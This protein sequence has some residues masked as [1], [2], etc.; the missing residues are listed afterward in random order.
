MSTKIMALCWPIVIPPTAKS[1]LISLADNANDDG[2][3]YPSIATI[4][5]RTCFKKDAVIDAIAWLERASLLTANRGN[6]R[7]TTYTLTP[8]NF[9][10]IEKASRRETS[11]AKPPVKQG[12]TTGR[13]KPPVGQTES[14]QSGKTTDQSGKTT[15]PV[16]QTDTNRQEPSIEPSLNHLVVSQ[17]DPDETSLQLACK[18]TWA[19]YSAAY[20]ARY[21]IQPVRNAKVSS[22][23]K[24]FVQRVG[25]ADAPAIAEFF[26]RLNDQFVVKRSHD[27]GTLL[28]NAE[29]YRTQCLTGTVMTTT[30]ANQLDR[31]ASNYDAVQEAIRISEQRGFRQ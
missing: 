15:K 19:S 29:G 8:K 23:V 25:Q 17:G 21:G 14:N 31:T 5:E 26:V 30:K 27:F 6:G 22:Q 2:Y 10:P 13:A 16:G 1:V 11:R 3:C 18:S 12:K 7:H 4:C 24:Q 20:Q 9:T 28:A